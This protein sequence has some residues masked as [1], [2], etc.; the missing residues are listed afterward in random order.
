MAILSE[1]RQIWRRKAESQVSLGGLRCFGKGD[2]QLE[3]EQQQGRGIFTPA[4]ALGRD[5]LIHSP[6]Y[7]VLLP[8]RQEKSCF[9]K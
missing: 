1:C 9:V 5:A 6:F 8:V 4:L 2:V 7:Y 3:L